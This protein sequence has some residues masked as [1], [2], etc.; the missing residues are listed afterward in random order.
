LALVLKLPT[1]GGKRTT[2]GFSERNLK[3]LAQKQ[4]PTLSNESHFCPPSVISFVSILQA[5]Y[6]FRRFLGLGQGTVISD[7]V[8]FQTLCKTKICEAMSEG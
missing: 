1:A 3:F 6:I 2:C 8:F 7:W 4:V 5:G